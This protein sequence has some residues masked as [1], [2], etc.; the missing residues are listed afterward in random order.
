MN[1]L[2]PQ[3][4]HALRADAERFSRRAEKKRNIDAFWAT[5]SPNSRGTLGLSMGSQMALSLV[6]MICGWGPTKHMSS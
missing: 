5:P 1:L 3:T 4:P 6:V 2:C